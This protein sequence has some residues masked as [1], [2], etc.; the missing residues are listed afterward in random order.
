MF[1]LLYWNHTEL[2]RQTQ[3][4]NQTVMFV[5]RYLLHP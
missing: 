3:G 2:L 5:Y 1:P 4:T